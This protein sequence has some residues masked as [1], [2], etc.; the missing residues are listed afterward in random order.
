MGQCEVCGNEY[1]KTFEVSSVRRIGWHLC[2]STVAAKSSDTA[3]RSKAASTAVLIAHAR[4]SRR[5]S[6]VTERRERD[7]TLGQP[8]RLALATW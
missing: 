6:C 5:T 4:G 2:A 3:L 8:S 1:D 7:V